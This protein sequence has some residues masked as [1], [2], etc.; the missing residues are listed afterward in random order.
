MSS[1][2]LM[3]DPNCISMFCAWKIATKDFI[4]D[5]LHKIVILRQF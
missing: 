2:K 1:N 4:S 5:T 3:T